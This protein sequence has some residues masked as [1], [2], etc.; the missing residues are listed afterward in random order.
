MEH[1]YHIGEIGLVVTHKKHI[2]FRQGPDNF[3]PIYF[4]F[5]KAL[6]PLMGHDPHYTDQPFFQEKDMPKR[7][8]FE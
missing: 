5:I 8:S 2:G 1:G 6:I 4:Q 7:I 3:R